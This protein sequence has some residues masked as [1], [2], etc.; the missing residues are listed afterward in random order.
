MDENIVR[1]WRRDGHSYDSTNEMLKCIF[2]IVDKDFS[3]R[4]VDCCLKKKKLIM[5]SFVCHLVISS[6]WIKTLVESLLYLL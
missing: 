1:N 2:P 5:T 3:E 6:D 4:F